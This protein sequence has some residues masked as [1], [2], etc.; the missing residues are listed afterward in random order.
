MYISD[1]RRRCEAVF[2]FFLIFLLL[3]IARLFYVQFFRFNYLAEIARKQH[4]FFVEL[5]PRRGTIFDINLKPQAVNIPVD[6]LYASPNSIKEKDKE[7]IITKLASI[8]NV[9][10]SYLRDRMSRK[11]SFI[12]LARKITSEQTEAIKKLNIKGLGFIRESKRSYPNSYLGSHILGFAG[13]D[14]TGLEGLEL[15]LNKYLR[16]EPGWGVY[17]RDARQNKLDLWQQMVLPKDGYDVVLTIDEVVQYIA[18]RELDKAFKTHNAKGACIVVMDP[19]TGAILALANRPTYDLND[20][21]GVN[22]DVTRNRAICDMFEP[23]SVFK[24]V[25]ASAAFEEK[26]VK[27][28]DRFFCEN[29]EYRVANHILHDHEPKGWLT[30]REVIEESSNIGTVKVAQMLGPDIVYRYMKLFGFGNKTGIDM[31]GEINGIAK[32]PRQWS[33]VSISAIPI[34]QEVGV[35][36]IQLAAAYSVFANGGQLMRP[37]IIQEVRDKQKEAIRRNSPVMISKVL[38]LDTASRMR[39]I[40]T[41]VVEEGTGKLAKMEGLSAAGKTGTAQKLEP[42]GAYSHSKFVASFIGFAP[43]EEPLVTIVVMVDEP[44]PNYYGGVVAAPVFKNVAHDVI[45][46]LKTIQQENVTLSL[47]ETKRAY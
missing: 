26:R 23:G 29:G 47:N 17:L 13:I 3:C 25:T 28:E 24:V 15:Y 40:L 4:N 7:I 37:Y 12:W 46:Y 18:E 33:K 44:H 9:N 20:H 22:K 42:N 19:H 6:S 30:F 34:G 10:S 11:K 5:E 35:T 1:Y 45:K 2:L 39:K 8:L 32:S 21:A 36:A 16:G 41:G 14:N 38:S 31:L 27:E 43:A